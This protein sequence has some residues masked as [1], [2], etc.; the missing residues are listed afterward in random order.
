MKPLK[1]RK[2]KSPSFEGHA[3]APSKTELS[4]FAGLCHRA[5][6]L[7]T[8]LGE[9]LAAA[10]KIQEELNE[11]RLKTIPDFAKSVGIDEI[12]IDGVGKTSIKS[13]YVASLTDKNKAGVINWTL[14]A[15][16]GSIIKK[17]IEVEFDSEDA[18]AD[19]KFMDIIAYLNSLELEHKD[20]QTIA[21]NTLKKFVRERIEAGDP[22]FSRDLFGVYEV[23]EVK[24][25][26][27]KINKLKS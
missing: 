18:Q 14:T 20:T 13:E 12:G 17:K 24:F 4:H 26:D 7:N 6:K 21:A 10:K 1:K 25:K 22:D 5:V 19:K 23:R 16:H 8:Q 2:K 27:V 15:G 9:Q 3:P 11:L